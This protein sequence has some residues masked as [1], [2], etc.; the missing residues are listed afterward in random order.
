MEIYSSRPP[1]NTNERVKIIEINREFTP[2]ELK[3]MAVENYVL[4]L[5][6]RNKRHLIPKLKADFADREAGVF[7]IS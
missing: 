5:V 7:I 1:S 4:L 2:Y 6:S 3:A